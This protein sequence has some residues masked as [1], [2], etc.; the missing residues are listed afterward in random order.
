VLL[1]LFATACASGGGAGADPAAGPATAQAP[2]APGAPGAGIWSVKTRE[3]IDLWLHAYA[4]V[5]DDT[6]QV[7]FF[8]RGYRARLTAARSQARVV[9]A[10][11]GAR[12]SLR[13]RLAQNPALVGGQFIPLSFATWDDMRRAID[14]FLNAQGNPQRARTQQE[15]FVIQLLAGYFPARAD[16][17]WLRSFA[18]GVEDER[19]KFYHDYWLRE[20]RDHAPVLAAIDSSWQRQHRPKLQRF[21]NNTQQQ[22]GELI[23]SLPLDGEGRTVTGSDQQNVMVVA[24][25]D[26]A[27]DAAEVAYLVAHE[28]VARIAATAISDNTTPTQKRTGEGDRLASPAAVRGGLLLL[29]RAAPELADGY[30][31]YY[32]RSANR[33]A[34]GANPRA[35]L[36]AAF[37]LQ[38]EIRDAI[39]R[40]LDI[41]LGGS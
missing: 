5:Q 29:E 3:H 26:R 36:E 22:N 39:A 12:D 14:S 41:V 27:A 38:V 37:P 20:Q 33:P 40:Q 35:A 7:P 15:A 31:R 10:L 2:G 28:A 8:E 16:R 32:L 11:D 18:A 4:L 1:S 13:T 25:P 34:T 17:D 23:L 30:A 24:M 6:A 19:L 21:L 9:T